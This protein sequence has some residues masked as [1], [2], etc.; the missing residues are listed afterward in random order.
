VAGALRTALGLTVVCGCWYTVLQYILAPP[1][2]IARL[3]FDAFSSP[4]SGPVRTPPFGQMVAAHTL[5]VCAYIF[6]ALC[7]AVLVAAIMANFKEGINP[8]G[9]KRYA[10][11][12]TVAIM[13]AATVLEVMAIA[14]GYAQTLP[15]AE[16]A[17]Q[18]LHHLIQYGMMAAP[19]T[20]GIL[21][22]YYHSRWMAARSGRPV[23][24][25]GLVDRLFLWVLAF[26]PQGG[27]VPS[28]EVTTPEPERDDD[29]RMIV[30]PS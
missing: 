15:G 20:Y 13:G 24:S 18:T 26:D 17:D 1:G 19:V 3:L 23:G 30:G 22:A 6:F 29:G 16:W 21:L 28:A 11:I 8:H 10:T 25:A 4:D 27:E 7:S 5:Y 2:S 12:H 9:V 14:S